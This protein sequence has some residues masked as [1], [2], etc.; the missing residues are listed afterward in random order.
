MCYMGVPYRFKFKCDF[1]LVKMK[2]SHVT[3]HILPKIHKKHF[4]S[5]FMFF[6]TWIIG[7]E[8]LK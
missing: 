6:E 2:G 5:C 1:G 3:N 4:G 8:V 7:N